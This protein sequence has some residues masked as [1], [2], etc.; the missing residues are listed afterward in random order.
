MNKIGNFY[1]HV[2]YFRC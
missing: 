2:R 1:V